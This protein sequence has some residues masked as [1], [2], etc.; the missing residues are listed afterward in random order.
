[1]RLQILEILMG[2]PACV[3][4]LIDRTG[5]HQAFI[6]Q[7][8]MLLRQT[9]L[10]KR[11]RIGLNMRY[12]IATESVKKILMCVMQEQRDTSI[13]TQSERTMLEKREMSD[14]IA[15]EPIAG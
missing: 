9:G 3:C 14:V 12:E 4:E 1:M 5:R 7:H 15:K 13:Q 2:G 10:V 11:T 8:L 6:S